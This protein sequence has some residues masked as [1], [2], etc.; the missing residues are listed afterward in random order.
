MV[1]RA[2]NKKGTC[3]HTQI[4]AQVQEVAAL[5]SESSADADSDTEKNLAAKEPPRPPSAR[6]HTKASTHSS[7]RPSTT[8]SGVSG[9]DDH[10]EAE[11]PLKVS[12]A[13]TQISGVFA[14]YAFLHTYTCAH[15]CTRSLTHPMCTP[16]CHVARCATMWHQRSILCLRS[17]FS[18]L[19]DK[20]VG[21]R[22][23]RCQSGGILPKSISWIAAQNFGSILISAVLNSPVHER[24]LRGLMTPNRRVS[25]SMAGGR[26]N[27]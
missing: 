7:F 27:G 25:S 20:R 14:M 5:D 18:C 21:R 4:H 1:F 13:P 16:L 26:T 8:R 2:W 17:N 15:A 22:R 19:G 10:E 11:L 24:T 3:T 23:K 6:P 9:L 12:A